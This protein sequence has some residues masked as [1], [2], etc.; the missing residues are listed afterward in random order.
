MKVAGFRVEPISMVDWEGLQRIRAWTRTDG[1]GHVRLR[2]WEG[3][4]EIVEG[5]DVAVCAG[6]GTSVVRLPKREGEG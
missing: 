3:E 1:A 4:R 2:V 5:V 6:E